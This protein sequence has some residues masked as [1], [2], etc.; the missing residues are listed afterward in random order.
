MGA[1]VGV[2]LAC[3]RQV[4]LAHHLRHRERRAYQRGVVVGLHHA[5]DLIDG[6][7]RRVDLRHDDT[8]GRTVHLLHRLG[9]A[10]VPVP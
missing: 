2:V 4:G 10:V 5:H 8:R 3:Q 6:A 7:L 1:L 9:E